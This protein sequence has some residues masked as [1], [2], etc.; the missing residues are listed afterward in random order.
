MQARVYDP[1]TAQFLTVDPLV[2]STQMPYAYA[3]DNPENLGDPTGYEAIPVPI[4]V[5]ACADP[6]T[7]AICAGAA[8]YTV[9]E[10]VKA[11][12]NATTG[13]EGG[14]EGEAELRA[15]QIAE[16]NCGE[17]DPNFNNPEELPG[18]GWEWKGKGPPG[19]SEGSWVNPETGE[20]LYPD[21]N[22]PEP[23]GPHYDYTAPDGSQWRIY[24]GGRIEPKP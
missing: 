17:F 9:V 18:P 13:E 2:A 12:Y 22:H 20:K 4:D 24:P 8:G 3:A 1:A 16:E 6:L 19:S 11:L 21:L 23:E 7:A 15:K 14:D 10:G 5:G